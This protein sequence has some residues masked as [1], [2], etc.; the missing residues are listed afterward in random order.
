M[1]YL[2]MTHPAESATHHIPADEDDRPVRVVVPLRA[3]RVSTQE[4]VSRIR[5]HLVAV[6]AYIQEP[7]AEAREDA[8]DGLSRALLEL[9]LL[10]RGA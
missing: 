1:Y 7:G 2:G 9:R 5:N 8:R 3:E 6:S 10:A 4:R